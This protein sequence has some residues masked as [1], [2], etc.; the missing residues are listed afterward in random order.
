MNVDDVLAKYQDH[1]TY[2]L[3]TLQLVITMMQARKATFIGFQTIEREK[4]LLNADVSIHSP[5]GQEMIRI[6]LFRG[7]E[8]TVEAFCS[9][10]RNHVLEELIDAFNYFSS[11][12]FLNGWGQEEEILKRMSAKFF[13]RFDV[14]ESFKGAPLKVDAVGFI[15]VSTGKFTDRLRNRAWMNHSQDAYL[16]AWKEY[17]EML[18]KILSYILPCFLSFSEFAAFFMAKDEVLQFRLRTMY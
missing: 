1:D 9:T 16:D 12:P 13:H 10:S 3:L 14:V 7:L 8:E 5:K 17:E 15:A 2:R 4:G 11:I 18:D 6:L